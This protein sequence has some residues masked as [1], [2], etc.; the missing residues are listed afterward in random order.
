MSTFHRLLLLASLLLLLGS[1]SVAQEQAT[2]SVIYR[3]TSF[4]AGA[5]QSPTYSNSRAGARIKV[6][7]M[8]VTNPIEAKLREGT[9]LDFFGEDTA[10][11]DPPAFSV[12]VSPGSLRGDLLVLLI[13]SGKGMK[14]ILLDLKKIDLPRGGQYVFNLL[15]VAVAVQ[16][17]EGAKPK[18]IQSG[19]TG[20][21]AA[22]AE[23]KV[24]QTLFYA[25]ENGKPQKFSSSIYFK[26][27]ESRQLVFC[28]GAKGAKLPKVAP[29]AIYDRKKPAPELG[30]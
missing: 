5:I 7:K 24:L 30:N 3:I 26:D 11:E 9:F 22:P 25:D 6:S 1:P 10:P 16:C 15:P 18:L 19:K 2:V 4:G 29:I 28:Y 12:K 27:K 14:P 20:S 13:Y 8:H 21:I 23:D 17:G